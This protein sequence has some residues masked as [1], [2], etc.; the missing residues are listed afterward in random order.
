MIKKAGRCL[1]ILLMLAGIYQPARCQSPYGDPLSTPL[2]NSI[3]DLF[4]NNISG[5]LIYNNLVFVEGA[6]WIRSQEELD[7][8]FRETQAMYDLVRSYGI[9]NVRIDRSPGE[10]TFSY[11][12]EAEFWITSPGKRLIARLEADPAMVANGS[13]SADVSGEL[14]YLPPMNEEEAMKMVDPANRD[15]YKGKIALM[16]SH[17]RGNMAS[18]L[19]SAG[20]TAVISFNSQE[21]YID[22]SEVI[23]SSG[24]YGR[25]KNLKTGIT[26]S[27]RQWSELLEDVQ[28]GTKL[29]ARCKTVIEQR[30]DRFES[31]FSWIPGTEPDKKGIF[32]T[33]HLFEGYIKR[34]ANDDSG[35]CMVQLEILRALNSLIESGEIERPKRNI[36]FLWPNEISGTY[37]FISRNPEILEKTGLNINMD[38]VTEGLR[39]NNAL[40][41]V[42]AAPNYLPTYYDGLANSIMNYVWRTNDIVYLPDSP[43]GRRGGQYFPDPMVEKNGSMDAFRYRV[44]ISTGGSDH[45]CFINSSV[46]VPGVSY[47][48]WPDYWY[49][50]DKD[51]PDKGDPTQMKR[52][53]FIGLATAYAASNCNDEVLPGIIDQ[54]TQFGYSRIGAMELPAALRIIR[55]SKPGELAGNSARAI[56]I[57][58]LGSQREIEALRSVEEIYSGSD[59]ARKLLANSISEME[60]YQSFLVSQVTEAVAISAGTSGVKVPQLTGASALEKKYEKIIPRIAPGVMYKIFSPGSWPAY[61]EYTRKNPDAVASKVAASRDSRNLANYIN[62]KRSVT[63]IWKDVTAETGSRITLEEVA[64]WFEMLHSTGYV[65]W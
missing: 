13:Q 38:M 29:S 19:D 36:Y 31:V 47:C 45:I 25:G 11:P 65:A 43:D 42:N 58:T 55:E 23:Y 50:T 52:M 20:I 17:A 22:P 12:V 57:V 59:Y 44:D 33:A 48:A 63:R 56:N 7:G 40:M 18:I 49:H 4:S 5:Q 28:F 54:T 41:T 61:N 46:A 34:G 53:A 37:N 51:T 26:L 3:L 30:K 8:T 14:I 6:P 39:K 32:F 62:G 21:R 1:T 60:N 16:W 15:K 24:S 10:R 27:W 64:E 2:P 35:G 9:E